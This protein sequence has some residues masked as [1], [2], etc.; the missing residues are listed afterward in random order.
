M[1]HR[2]GNRCLEQGEASVEYA[3]Y[4]LPFPAFNQKDVPP[5]ISGDRT[6]FLFN[7]SSYHF[8]LS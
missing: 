7:C 6:T 2:A 3:E 4:Y 8:I 1:H 5:V